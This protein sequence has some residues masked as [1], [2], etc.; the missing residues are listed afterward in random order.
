MFYFEKGEIRAMKI[1]HE[2]LKQTI[3]QSKQQY[4]NLD[5]KSYSTKL[6]E[7]IDILI[8]SSPVEWIAIG[9]TI[10]KEGAYQ[11]LALKEGREIPYDT[12]RTASD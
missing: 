1:S 4:R 6:H 11:I 7:V 2:L 5:K 9:E 3:E 10:M 12:N 8:S